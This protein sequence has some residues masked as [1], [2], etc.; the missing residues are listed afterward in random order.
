MIVA[1]SLKFPDKL[2]LGIEIR[3]KPVNF[4]GEKLISLRK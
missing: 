3:E 2:S 1:L 4:I